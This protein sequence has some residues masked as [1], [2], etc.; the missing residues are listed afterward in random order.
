[1]KNEI[2]DEERLVLLK[3]GFTLWE[4]LAY[5]YGVPNDVPTSEDF[6]NSNEI[7]DEDLTLNLTSVKEEKENEYV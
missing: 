4:I 6:D 3:K 2:S 1:M 5:E 7:T